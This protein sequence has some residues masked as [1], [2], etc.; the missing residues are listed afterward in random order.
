MWFSLSS[1]PAI[2]QNSTMASKRPDRASTI[3][4][5]EEEAEVLAVH[6]IDLLAQLEAQLRAVRQTM[7]SIAKLRSQKFRVGPDLTNGQRMETLKT[8]SGELAAIDREL[9]VQHQSCDD[10]QR[11][12]R[13]MQ[14]RLAS[15]RSVGGIELGDSK[16]VAP[17]RVRRTRRG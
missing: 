13:E 10:M 15:L 7:L 6:Q 5:F 12:I 4:G 3:K 1:V 14:A 17:T 11:S 8:L 16:V 2:R 9:T